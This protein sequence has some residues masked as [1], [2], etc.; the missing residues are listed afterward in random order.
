MERFVILA[1][2]LG[3][4]LAGHHDMGFCRDKDSVRDFDP[5]KFTGRW[6]E[7]F[8]YPSGKDIHDIDYNNLCQTADNSMFNATF[9]NATMAGVS[10]ST[11]D[12]HALHAYVAIENEPIP[13]Q[14]GHYRYNGTLFL[15]ESIDDELPMQTEQIIA[16]D[17]ENF[18]VFY[19]CVTHYKDYQPD[20][21]TQWLRI[22][23]RTI[24]PADG[25]VKKALDAA[26]SQGLDVEPLVPV[27]QGD[28]G[29]DCPYY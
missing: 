2:F 6:Y 11:G 25:V 7:L 5:E 3:L 18:A 10:N 26:T 19:R 9:F 22:M 28:E 8:R 12:F 29:I 24:Y 15:F 14:P 27:Q 23:T 13:E 21:R 17:Y 4:S 20:W 1:L 16:T